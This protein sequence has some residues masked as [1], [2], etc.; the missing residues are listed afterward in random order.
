MEIVHDAP[1]PLC[2]IWHGA[3]ACAVPTGNP[4]TLRVPAVK[5]RA[6]NLH[7]AEVED[8]QQA[9]AHSDAASDQLD[10]GS[11]STVCQFCRAL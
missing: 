10:I 5:H 3:Q 7:S 1:C 4:N 11:M 8:V 6:V 2:N 9:P